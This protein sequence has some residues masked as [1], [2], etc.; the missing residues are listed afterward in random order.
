MS[1]S[2]VKNYVHIVFSTKYREP[3]IIPAVASDLYEYIGGI[4]SNLKCNPVIV[5]GYV[6]HMHILCLLSKNIA[7]ANLV[8]DIKGDSSLWIKTKF[9]GLDNFYWQNG[10]GAFSVGPGH[11]EKVKK[12]IHNQ[13]EHHQKQTF[14]DEFRKYLHRYKIDYDERYVWD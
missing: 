3:T 4:C 13:Y 1:Q 2:L 7:L 12:Y 14:Q 5:G 9:L 8:R 10:Y 6:D 11:V